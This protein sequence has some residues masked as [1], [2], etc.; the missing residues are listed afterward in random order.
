MHIN[1]I[2]LDIGLMIGIVKSIG[3]GVIPSIRSIWCCY[4]TSRIFSIILYLYL[5]IWL[6][7]FVNG[8]SF[9]YNLTTNFSLLFVYFFLFNQD[10]IVSYAS[11]LRDSYLLLQSFCL[12]TTWTNCQECK[13]SLF[14]PPQLFHYQFII[15]SRQF[16]FLLLA[17]L[18]HL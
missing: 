17:F 10:I 11:S 14:V 1:I 15:I 2:V 7:F 3:C 12:V 16:C 8:L 6:F 9:L 5:L 18:R 4:P 13:V